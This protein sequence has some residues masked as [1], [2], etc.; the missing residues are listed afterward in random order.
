MIA[1]I[2]MV[3]T[4]NRSIEDQNVDRLLHYA[5][6]IHQTSDSTSNCLPLHLLQVRPVRQLYVSSIQPQLCLNRTKLKQS[7]SVFSKLIV[8][9]AGGSRAF[10][11]EESP[12]SAQSE[13]VETK[14]IKV[15]PLPTHIFSS[16]QSKGR[17]L[18]KTQLEFARTEV[19]VAPDR[20]HSGM[21][22]WVLLCSH[23]SCLMCERLQQPF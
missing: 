10:S 19:S 4:N 18:T 8:D 9:D 23:P 2:Q 21:C 1:P 16:S 17:K 7:K 20:L 22:L 14:T 11:S 3:L 5:S 12:D 15:F 6:K 13:M